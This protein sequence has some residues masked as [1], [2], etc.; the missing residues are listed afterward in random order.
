M[1]LKH[2]VT[3]AKMDAGDVKELK[4]L[5]VAAAG[6]NRKSLPVTAADKSDSESP[7]SDVEVDDTDDNTHQCMQEDNFGICGFTTDSVDVML[8]HFWVSHPDCIFGGMRLKN[9][10]TQTVH[11]QETPDETP[12]ADW[13]HMMQHWLG[14][15]RSLFTKDLCHGRAVKN[16][17]SLGCIK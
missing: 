17:Y 15:D 4:R 2:N 9:L 13:I 16:C 8:Q 11:V 6:K 14:S 7:S 3:L 1:K 12:N 10:S 5:Q